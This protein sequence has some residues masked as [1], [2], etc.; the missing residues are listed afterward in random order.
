MIAEKEALELLKRYVDNEKTIKHCLG[1]AEVAFEI[2]TKINQKNPSLGI[3]PE[4]V[5]IAAL[6]HDIGRAKEGV[7]EF[8]TVEILENEG[9]ADLA[10]IAF[11]GFVYESALLKGEKELDKYLPFSI[12]NKIIV[13]ADMHYNQKGQN[14][15]LKERFADI[16]ERYKDDKDFLEILKLAKPRMEKL[17]KEI[18]DLM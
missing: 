14:V 12:E 10:K 17:E 11:H 4:K 13:I 15:N 1:V 18:N 16:K 8:N 5:K 9:L 2:A 7:H 6:L 3:N